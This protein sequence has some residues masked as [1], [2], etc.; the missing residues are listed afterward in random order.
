[1]EWNFNLNCLTFLKRIKRRN[2]RTQGKT[3]ERRGSPNPRINGKP[4]N[5]PFKE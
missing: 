3:P 4:K 1:M 5:K 2:L